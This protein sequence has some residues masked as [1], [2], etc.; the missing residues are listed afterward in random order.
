MDASF[1]KMDIFFFVSTLAV[2]FVS[3]LGILVLYYIVRIV[4]DISEITQCVKEEAHEIAQDF[5][6]VRAD[7]KDGVHEVRENVEEGVKTAKNYTRAVAGTGIVKAI[8]GFLEALAEEKHASARR[9]T[10]RK[11]KE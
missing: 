5:K 8:S 10:S 6:E 4:R 1:L 3:V 11:K 7:I 2:A 9:R